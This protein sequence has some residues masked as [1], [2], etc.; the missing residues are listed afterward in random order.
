M[1]ALLL[2]DY[3][4]PKHKKISTYPKTVSYPLYQCSKNSYAS[5]TMLPISN[6]FSK[7]I[8]QLRDLVRETYYDRV[9]DI[10]SMFNVIVCNYYT[11]DSHQ[12]SDHRDD[13]RWLKFNELDNSSNPEAS[14][15]A[16][17][18]FYVDYEP[19]ILR[20]FE[21]YNEN[22]NSWNKY[23][24]RH[25]PLV[26]FSNHRYRTKCIGKRGKSCKRVNLTFRTLTSGLLGLTGY[27]NFYR[28]MSIPKKNFI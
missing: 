26:L 14:I 13:E 12:I 21:I 5:Y 4:K 22:T 11:V 10:D 9:I 15:I 25:N 8:L 7:I 17:L 19:Y 2:G 1:E 28:Y 27:G 24:L 16:S 6:I 23:Q 3:L 18:T 20:N